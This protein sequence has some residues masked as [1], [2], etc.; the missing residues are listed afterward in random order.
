MFLNIPLLG[1]IVKGKGRGARSKQPLED[2]VDRM[3]YYVTVYILCI[4]ALLVG[5]KQHFGSP[6]DCFISAEVD[7]VRSWQAYIL[8][9]CFMQ[10]TFRYEIGHNAT[11]RSGYSMTPGLNGRDPHDTKYIGVKYYQWVPFFFA[12]Q[13]LCFML[14]DFFWVYIQSYLYIDMAMIVTESAELQG[15]KR[16]SN[17]ASKLSNIS[18]Y[19]FSYFYY[20]K[21]ARRGLISSVFRSPAIATVFYGCTKFL[22]LLNAIIQLYLTTYFLGF[23]DMHWGVRMMI[24]FLSKKSFPRM[25]GGV[26]IP[27]HGGLSHFPYFPLEVGCNYTK[28]SNNN[29]IHISSIQCMIPLNYINEKLFLFLWFWIVILIMITIVNIVLFFGSIMNKGQRED[30]ILS[31]LREKEDELLMNDKFNLAQKFVH[32]FMGVDGVLLTRFIKTKAGSM[33]CRDVV[34]RVWQKY[35]RE[36]GAAKTADSDDE[37]SVPYSETCYSGLPLVKYHDSSRKNSRRV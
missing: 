20:R 11:S 13:L 19:I 16:A 9:Y 28:I 2:H 26:R 4:F 15:E 36:R 30:A 22:Y 25:V 37:W 31:L 18:D 23:P 14:P 21:I 24:A 1:D 27:N 33:A 32:G 34:Q 29:N 5:S 17:R 12:F 35:A 10:G 6:I 8:D 3:H 7:K